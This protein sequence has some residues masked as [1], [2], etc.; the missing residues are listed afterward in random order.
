M[1]GDRVVVNA[2]DAS[3]AFADATPAGAWE[4]SLS[5]RVERGAFLDR[6]R[7]VVVTDGTTETVLGHIEDSAAHPANIVAAAAIATA[8]GAD[9]RTI[10]PGLDRPSCRRG[11]QRLRARSGGVP[12]LDDGMAA[13]PT[14]GAA[15]LARYPA[16]SVV[17]IAGGLND[18]GGGTVHATPAEIALLEQACDVIARVARV[19]VLFGEAGPRLAPLLARRSVELIETS[20]LD[21]GGRRRCG[22]SGRRHG[23][24]VLA[25][26]PGHARRPGALRRAGSS[27][28]LT[29]GY[30]SSIAAASRRSSKYGFTYFFNS[31]NPEHGKKQALEHLRASSL[32]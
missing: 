3:A 8:A 5:R 23:S 7:G 12:V 4:I 24:G 27:I 19:V 17:L 10:A 16:G 1:P 14:K 9:P 2:D 30:V 32:R 20:D 21:D 25:A 15:T 26:V 28:R 13:T 22:A 18:A 29:A 6:E 11:A 31:Q